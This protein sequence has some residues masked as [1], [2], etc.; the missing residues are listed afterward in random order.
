[1]QIKIQQGNNRSNWHL[2]MFMRKSI[3]GNIMYDSDMFYQIDKQGDTNKLIGL[4]DSY[5]HLINSI[6][7]GWRWNEMY[8]ALE[9]STIVSNNS[10]SSIQHL[11]FVETLS[12]FKKFSIAIHKTQYIVM[13]DGIFK[14]LPRTSKWYLPKYVLFP[15]FGGTTKSPTDFNFVFQLK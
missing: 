13:F 1:M 4:S 3:S 8:G 9:I 2:P 5:H 6:R 15:Y 7:L 14:I 10:V 12:E 11:C